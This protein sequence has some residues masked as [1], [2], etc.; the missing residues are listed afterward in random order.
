MSSNLTKDITM[1]RSRKY[2]ISQVRET[3]ILIEGGWSLR[4]VSRMTDIPY[5][6]IHGWC[7]RNK[8]KMRPRGG[9]S[10]STKTLSHADYELVANLYKREYSS[11]EIGE[12]LGLNDSTIRNRLY[13]AGVEMRSRTEA[14][15]LAWRKRNGKAGREAECARLLTE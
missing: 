13:R 3:L 5:S 6:T 1:S 7:E 12:M 15:Q 2:T 10:G 9:I 8:I 14:L 11:T 4:E